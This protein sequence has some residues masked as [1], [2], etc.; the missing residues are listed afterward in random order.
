MLLT[1]SGGTV[2]V[3]CSTGID[4]ALVELLARSCRAGSRRST[5]RRATAARRCTSAS[6]RIEPKPSSVILKPTIA[7]LVLRSRSSVVICPARTPAILK[8]PPSIRPNAL[9][10]STLNS[11]PAWSSPAPP[12]SSD[13]RRAGGEQDE[14]WSRRASPLRPREELGGVAVVVR[15]RLPR[16][17]LVRRGELGAARAAVALAGRGDLRAG[18]VAQRHRDRLDDAVDVGEGV[19]VGA[20]AAL[21]AD[22][23]R[24]CRSGRSRRTS[25]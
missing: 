5:R 22:A 24:R 23:R 4:V 8:S 11:L 16:V 10:S 2:L 9:S 12:A 1:R 20:D 7:R 17:R 18:V 25:R 13:E 15:R 3:V 19:D 6:V 21:A 14:R